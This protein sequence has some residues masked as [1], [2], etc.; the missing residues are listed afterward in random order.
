MKLSSS[1]VKKLTFLFSWHYGIFLVVFMI[2]VTASVYGLRQNNLTMISLREQ[3]YSTDK[4]GGDVNAA[5]NDLRTYVYGHMNTNLSSGGNA[6]KPPIQLKYTYERLVVTERTRIEKIN[7]QIYTDAQAY[8]EQQNPASFSGRSRV[9]CIEDYVSRNG[10]K[11]QPIPDALYKFDFVSP[12]W[13]SDL[14]GWS[15]IVSFLSALASLATL[16]FDRWVRANLS[17]I[18]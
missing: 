15:L 10:I 3:V 17:N 6:I 14:A 1:T 2:S 8:C 16:I 9:P 7:A 4:N 12:G 5:L 11:E 13:S 18:S